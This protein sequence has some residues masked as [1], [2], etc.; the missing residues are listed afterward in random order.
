MPGSGR[1]YI[2]FGGIIGKIGM[3]PFEFYRSSNILAYSRVFVRDPYQAWYLRGL[4]GIG[5]DIHAVGEYL[6]KIIDTSGADKVTFVGNSMGGYAALLFCAMLKTGSAIAFSPQTFIS[7]EMRML[8]GDALW[9]DKISPLTEA[10]VHPEAH[11]LALWIQGHYREMHAR[12]IVSDDDPL[13][14]LHAGELSHFPNIRVK[15]FPEGGHKLVTLL[16]DKGLLEGILKTGV[17]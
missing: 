14:C 2:F 9:S 10:P 5:P 15:Q 13:D 8:H 1:I 11:D 7:D 4:P 12:L 6:E 3:P 16:R 17:R